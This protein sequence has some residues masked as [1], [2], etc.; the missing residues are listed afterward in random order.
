MFLTIPVAIAAAHSL[1]KMREQTDSTTCTNGR[2]RGLFD[3]QKGHHT[4][5]NDN[6]ALSERTRKW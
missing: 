2:P 1:T 6:F 3:Q 5:M 4:C